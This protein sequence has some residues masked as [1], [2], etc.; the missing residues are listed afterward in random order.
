MLSLHVHLILRLVFAQDIDEFPIHRLASPVFIFVLQSIA[1]TKNKK[2][3]IQYKK[4]VAGL[5]KKH[6]LIFQKS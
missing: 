1:R 5:K 4:F 2:I 6:D 3:S